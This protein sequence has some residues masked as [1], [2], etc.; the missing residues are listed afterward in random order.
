M[1][2]H[3]P[4]KTRSH[5]Y[6]RSHIPKKWRGLMAAPAFKGAKETNGM[7]LYMLGGLTSPEEESN[8]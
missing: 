5:I 2:Y 8:S 7:Q 1:L 3:M 6:A 4:T